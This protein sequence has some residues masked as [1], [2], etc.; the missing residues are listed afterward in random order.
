ATRV[1]CGVEEMIISFVI[2]KTPAGPAWPDVRQPHATAA[3]ARAVIK[4]AEHQQE[5]D[6]REIAH[7]KKKPGFAQKPEETRFRDAAQ[8]P[9]RTPGFV[10]LTGS[11]K[12]TPAPWRFAQTPAAAGS[13]ERQ[14]V[15]RRILTFRTRPNA[16]SVA[17]SDD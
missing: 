15:N 14:F 12:R 11:R 17:T 9:D 4:T 10:P 7:K 5:A 2:A 3:G 1:S 6:R 13:A 16:A 8:K